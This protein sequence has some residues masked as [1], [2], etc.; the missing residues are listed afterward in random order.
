M[1]P[2]LPGPRDDAGREKPA[3][4]AAAKQVLRQSRTFL[5]HQA[6]RISSML[7]ERVG[8]IASELRSID[9]G[10]SETGRPVTGIANQAADVAERVAGYLHSA[11][12]QKLL[13]DA[14]ALAARNPAMAAGTAFIVGLAVSRFLKTSSHARRQRLPE[15]DGAYD[16]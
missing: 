3:G 13:V 16:G 14:E 11:D 2:Q 5:D 6:D 10:T 12:G 9:L 1:T 4:E 7:G 8:A 15:I